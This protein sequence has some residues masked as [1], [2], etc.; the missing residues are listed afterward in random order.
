[1]SIIYYDFYNN[2]VTYGVTMTLLQKYYSC[3][4]AI[5]RSADYYMSLACHYSHYRFHGKASLFAD[6]L[7]KPSDWLIKDK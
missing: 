5:Y 6:V 3:T 1:M 7:R 4:T 2:T